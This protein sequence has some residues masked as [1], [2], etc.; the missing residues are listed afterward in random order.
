MQGFDALAPQ[1]AKPCNHFKG[2]TVT[3]FSAGSALLF[4]VMSK[5]L[6]QELNP[7]KRVLGE[8]SQGN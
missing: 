7:L 5:F 6:S 4:C 1:N 3:P 8:L 2:Y